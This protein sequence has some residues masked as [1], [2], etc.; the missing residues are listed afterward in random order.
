MKKQLMIVMLAIFFVSVYAVLR[1]GPTRVA[2]TT[3]ISYAKDIQPIL[4]S[5]CGQCHM[6]EFVSKD[7]HMDTYEALMAGS[8]NGPVIIP[9][10]AGKKYPIPI[11][12][13]MARKIQRVR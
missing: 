12:T 9:G 2:P 13:A 5:R 4:E 7:L 10:T 3:E 8:Q 1:S 6:D 11:P